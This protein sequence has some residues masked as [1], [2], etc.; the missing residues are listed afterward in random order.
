MKFYKLLSFILVGLLTSCAAT[1]PVPPTPP[2]PSP[3][4][5]VLNIWVDRP[6][7]V[8]NEKV[9]TGVQSTRDCYLSLYNITPDGIVRQIFPNQFAS[10][11]LIRANLSYQIP[12]PADEFDFQV[13]GPTGIETIQ[14]VCTTDNIPLLPDNLIDRGERFPR[15]KGST[16]EFK[17]TVTKSLAVVPK[18]QKAEALIT[19]RTVRSRY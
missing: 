17:S 13:T 7:Y 16:S 3:S 10:D 8:I 2:P 4:D 15:I 5:F 1:T 6:E 14:A 12:D 19:F 11:N 9:I 18:G